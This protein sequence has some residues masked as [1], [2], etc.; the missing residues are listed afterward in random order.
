MSLGKVAEEVARRNQFETDKARKVANCTC[1][2]VEA[3]FLGTS[4]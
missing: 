2:F 4:C 3:V 1:V